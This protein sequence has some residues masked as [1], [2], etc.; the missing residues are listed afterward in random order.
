M[1]AV[2]VSTHSTQFAITGHNSHY[3]HFFFFNFWS[4]CKFAAMF[5]GL[6][7][8]PC[9]STGSRRI[10]WLTWL[11]CDLKTHRR[12]R[13]HQHVKRSENPCG[14][15]YMMQSEGGPRKSIRGSSYGRAVRCFPSADH[16]NYVSGHEVLV[17]MCGLLTS[18]NNK[19]NQYCWNI[20]EEKKHERSY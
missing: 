10:M 3:W 12:L 14:P 6:D 2:L 1:W 15:R 18:Q 7:P 8:F 16:V 9:L 13:W 20:G 4:L 17:C 19:K 11:T 5:S